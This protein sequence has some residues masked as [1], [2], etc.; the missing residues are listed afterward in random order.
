MHTVCIHLT[1]QGVLWTVNFIT[2]IILFSNASCFLLLRYVSVWYRDLNLMYPYLMFHNQKWDLDL[3]F[4][5]PTGS[6]IYFITFSF[7]PSDYIK[8]KNGTLICLQFNNGLQFV[9]A[10]DNPEVHWIAEITAVWQPLICIFGLFWLYLQVNGGFQPPPHSLTIRLMCFM[11]T[12]CRISRACQ[13]I[14]VSRALMRWSTLDFP[15]YLAFK[16]TIYISA[17]YIRMVNFW[18]GLSMFLEHL[19]LLRIL[20]GSKPLLFFVS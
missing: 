16:G 17:C 13:I 18:R 10:W 9:A 4:R 6:T 14:T 2:Y 12:A 3:Y 20:K 11:F 19:L 7:F 1:V 8:S 15:L 5:N